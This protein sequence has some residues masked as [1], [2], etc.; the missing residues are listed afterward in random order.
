MTQVIKKKIFKKYPS[1]RLLATPAG[2]TLLEVMAAI[3]IMAIALVSVYKMHTQT[4]VMANTARFY[5]TAPFLAQ[6]KIS[7]IESKSDDEL[8]D[9]SGDF[10]DKFPQ[11]NYNISINDV[12]SELPG[13]TTNDLKKIDITISYNTDE[14]IYRLRTYRFVQE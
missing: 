7:E 4:I 13:N 10:G 6:S 12:E 8:S 3:S 11:Y 14:F 5:T 1:Y 2:F 9:G